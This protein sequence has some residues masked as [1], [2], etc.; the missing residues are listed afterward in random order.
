MLVIPQ[1]LKV[2]IWEKSVELG[3]STRD[4]EPNVQLVDD[5][6]CRQSFIDDSN[7]WQII[8]NFGD[9]L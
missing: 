3:S 2:K 5:S 9:D 4:C 6:S 7:T 1:K 8:G